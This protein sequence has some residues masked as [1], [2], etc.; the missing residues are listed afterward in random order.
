MTQVISREVC[1]SDEGIPSAG[2]RI[3]E[4]RDPRDHRRGRDASRLK[5]PPQKFSVRFVSELLEEFYKP[6]P[7]LGCGERP[8]AVHCGGEPLRGGTTAGGKGDEEGGNFFGTTAGGKG[9]EEKC[10]QGSSRTPGWSSPGSTWTGW[11]SPGGKEDG[12]ESGRTGWS[13]P[14]ASIPDAGDEQHSVLSE[15]AFSLGPLGTTAAIF[16]GFSPASGSLWSSPPGP[17]PLASADSTNNPFPTPINVGVLSQTAAVTAQ[18]PDPLLLRGV[19]SRLLEENKIPPFAR[20]FRDTTVVLLNP[21]FATYNLRGTEMSLPGGA[22]GDHAGDHDQQIPA[23]DLAKTVVERGFQDE[24]IRDATIAAWKDVFEVFVEDMREFRAV[25]R[26]RLGAVRSQREKKPGVALDRIAEVDEVVGFGAGPP[27]LR[28]SPPPGGFSSKPW[29][30]GREGG[31][32]GRPRPSPGGNNITPGDDVPSSR[33]WARPGGDVGA[34]VGRGMDEA[35]FGR[36]I[37]D[38][39]EPQPCVQQ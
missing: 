24:E 33:T 32:R 25:R 29:A 10:L 13:S 3:G 37:V 36:G 23:H 19:A 34:A 8:S 31:P 5:C 20:S 1:A 2:F 28:P 21:D 26:R 12:G 7:T 27:A 17:A 39:A 11:S 22:W 38:A 15:D 30:P 6:N 14:A 18:S 35:P 16:D 4:V 9:D